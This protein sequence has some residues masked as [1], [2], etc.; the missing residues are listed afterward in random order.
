MPKSVP[1]SLVLLLDSAG[2]VDPG[3]AVSWRRRPVVGFRLY[4]RAS[5]GCKEPA[6]RVGDF[7]DM[8]PGEVAPAV[9]IA[10]WGCDRF[11]FRPLRS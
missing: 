10:A 5:A 11:D 7:P 8:R 6:L 2:F 9:A 4:D 1:L 3:F